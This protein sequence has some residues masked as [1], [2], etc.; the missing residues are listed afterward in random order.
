[1]NTTSDI[2][3]RTGDTLFTVSII[4]F[5]VGNFFH[6]NELNIRVQNLSRQVQKLYSIQE[7]NQTRIATLEKKLTSDIQD[8]SEME[9]E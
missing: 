5:A 9:L 2:L 4:F 6:L 3:F 1:M 8:P 7:Y